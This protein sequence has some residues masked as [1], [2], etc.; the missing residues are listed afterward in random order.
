MLAFQPQYPLQGSMLGDQR[1]GP[2]THTTSTGDV[3][4]GSWQY[5]QRHGQGT[6]RAASGMVYEGSWVDDKATGYANSRWRSLTG[7]AS[8]C[9]LGAFLVQACS[10]D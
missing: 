2:G 8:Y 7:N 6:F 10:Q 1:H 9:N 5:D 4:E 3:Y